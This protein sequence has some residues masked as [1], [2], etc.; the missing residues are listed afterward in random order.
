MKCPCEGC[1]C[2]PICRGRDYTDIVQKCS[3]VYDYLYLHT[4]DYKGVMNKNQY[5]NRVGYISELLDG[6][7]KG[8]Q[9]HQEYWLIR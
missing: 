8:W 3:I 2:R 7:S 5:C 6:K 1:I 4:M 9:R